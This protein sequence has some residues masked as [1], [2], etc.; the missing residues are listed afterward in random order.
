MHTIEIDEQ[1]A[2]FTTLTIIS[3]VPGFT[4]VLED[5]FDT[6][7]TETL[8]GD[9]LGTSPENAAEGVLEILR[10]RARA[11]EDETDE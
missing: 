2:T 8:M 5:F 7:D 3:D 9:A 10:K 11:W 1:G 6:V 4:D